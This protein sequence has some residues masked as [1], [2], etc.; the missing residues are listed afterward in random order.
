MYTCPILPVKDF[1]EPH[2]DSQAVDLGVWFFA[3]ISFMTVNEK[4][5]NLE[6]MSYTVKKM[7]S[8]KP[9]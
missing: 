8:K 9:E 1:Y 3:T 2:F 6:T 5:K 7:S 4:E